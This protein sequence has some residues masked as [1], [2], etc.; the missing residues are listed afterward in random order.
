MATAE[1]IARI[2]ESI[3]D[4]G[5]M[6]FA[7]ALGID[8]RGHAQKA[9]AA[10][11]IHNGSDRNLALMVRDR[12]VLWVC[13]SGC[14]GQGGDALDLIAAVHGLDII[15]NF[16]QVVEEAARIASV[17]VAQTVRRDPPRETISLVSATTVLKS[18]HALCPLRGVGLEYVRDT[19]CL[20]ETACV[21]ARVGY[22]ENPQAVAEK[23]LELYDADSLDALGVVYRG[24]RLAFQDHR[25][26]F[27]IV[28]DDVIVYVQGRSLGA[29]EKKSDRW[30]SMRGSVPCP[31]GMDSV[32]DTK[33]PIIAAE[34]PIDW[35]S[36]TE[37]FPECAAIGV[38][39]AGSFRD[40]WAPWFRGRDVTLA[41]DPDAAGDMGR[42]KMRRLLL[43]V[44]ARVRGLEIPDGM[45]LNAWLCAERS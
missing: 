42:D 17:A 13:H 22:V 33:L 3:A 38:V 2:H 11:P 25:L 1:E 37:F 31:Y 21:K 45:D 30:R 4:R 29:V 39:G 5:V 7:S 9:R 34:G 14:G 6:Q 40:E 19:R 12:R 10:C 28:R 20:S 35:I 26:L 24:T 15:A 32:V 18:L 27:P 41:L 36:A 16:K 8:A 43:N 44:G 23:L